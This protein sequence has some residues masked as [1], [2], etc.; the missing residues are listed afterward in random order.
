MDQRGRS[1]ECFLARLD[2]GEPSHDEANRMRGGR[3]T[4][5]VGDRDPRIAPGLRA[6][7]EGAWDAVIDCS[8][9]VPRVVEAS[10]RLLASRVSRYIFVSSMS[11]YAKTDH[12]NMD[13][14]T[15]VATLEDSSTEQVLEH[16]GAL[17]AV[18]EAVVDRIYAGGAA[19][20]RPGLIVG[21][22][23]ATDRF[24]YWVARFLHPHLLG[25]RPPR[26]VV[27][28]PPSRPVQFIDARDLAGWLTELARRDV[29][30][31]F[32]A[33]SAAMQWRFGDLVGALV[34]ASP[35]PPDPV[36]IDDARLL[37][38]GVSPWVGLPLWLP[39]SEPDSGGFMAM[40]CAR[41]YEAGLAI[42]P[43]DDTIVATAAWLVS[44]DNGEAWKHVL[45]AQAERTLLQ[46]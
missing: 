43:L 10:A 4:A 35:A 38:H 25:D 42:R 3:L 21:P 19:H 28:A 37:A 45:T 32:N 14:R 29:G 5:L 34:A 17:K 8:G 18:C 31:I 27:P 36:W 30:G 20:V 23:D 46:T 11:V 44:R 24:G 39:E 16:Y 33:C 12:P 15:P 6:L 22:F 40:S 9:Y 26:A 7:E 41:A 13:E 1:G 2:E